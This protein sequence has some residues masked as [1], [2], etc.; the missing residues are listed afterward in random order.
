MKKSIIFCAVLAAFLLANFK[1]SATNFAA[2][3][4]S[5][6]LLNFS[7]INSQSHTVSVDRY[8]SNNSLFGDIVI[9][10]NISYNGVTYTVTRIPSWGFENCPMRSISIP[11]S[12]TYIGT[13]AFRDCDSLATISLPDSV[14]HWGVRVFYDCVSLTSVN[15]PYGV[16][17]IEAKAFFNCSNLQSI[18][19]PNN[20]ATI[21]AG[22]FYNCS[23]LQSI[24]IPNS[25]TSI[26]DSAF[27]NS[28]LTSIIIPDNVV[29]VGR[30]AFRGCNN[31]LSATIGKGVTDLSGAP[32]GYC[33]NLT[34][35][36][37]NAINCS[38][39]YNN[40]VGQPFVG[41]ANVTSF[42]IGPEVTR[43]PYHLCSQMR[44]LT[45]VIIPNSVTT[46][47]RGAFQECSNL[48]FVSIGTGI[49]NMDEYAF[50]MDNIKAV[51]FNAINCTTSFTDCPFADAANQRSIPVFT[52]GN[53]VRRI[54]KRLC[55]NVDSLTS[56]IIPSSVS[57]IGEEAFHRCS[58]LDTVYLMPQTPPELHSYSA[59]WFNAPDRVFILS[60]CSEYD[61][62]AY[63]WSPYASDFRYPTYD[64]SINVNSND[65][66][67]GIAHVIPFLDNNV[68]CDSSAVIEA[69]PNS[70]YHFDH[71]SN[72]ST[73]R[74][75]TLYLI[76][77]T[78]IIA[79]FVPEGGSEGV[80]DV[81]QDAIHVLLKNGR[82]IVDGVKS[83]DVQVFD[84]MGRQTKN[85]MLPNGVYLVKIGNHPARKVVVIR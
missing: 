2:F 5:G 46:I 1:V 28:G 48:N 31:L 25:V 72:G 38:T 70:G 13:E 53:D 66:I 78:T 43:I 54:P 79:Y 67:R 32:L 77:D 35:I 76:G 44:N 83:E 59:F 42:V 11:N 51:E 10:T 60:D 61:I 21:G 30:F 58:S 64:I 27:K 12:V 37:F 74:T 4:P 19:I 23:N 14:T 55:Y 81:E 33:T 52:F 6:H 39:D 8:A 7:I 3:T 36:T 20:V 41:C 9:P 65:T 15:I 17:N 56:V 80:F 16:T 47:E 49:T 34:S 40:N 75:D 85:D 63:R 73:N 57:Y 18:S 45:S 62:Y 82:I 29:T 69:L 26:G 84:I 24:G 68:R 22:A 50:S 71:W